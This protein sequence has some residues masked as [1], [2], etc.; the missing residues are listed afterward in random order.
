MPF[1]AAVKFANA[2]DLSSLAEDE[3]Q[4]GVEESQEDE[5]KDEQAGGEDDNE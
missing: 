5:V 2:F 1:A 4:E 3:E